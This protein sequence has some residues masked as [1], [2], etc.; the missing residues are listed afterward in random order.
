M[1]VRVPV[2]SKWSKVGCFE[3]VSKNLNKI[4]TTTKLTRSVAHGL[5]LAIYGFGRNLHRYIQTTI[6]RAS[7]IYIQTSS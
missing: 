1:S 3:F 7:D 2:W 5:N 4:C 6:S